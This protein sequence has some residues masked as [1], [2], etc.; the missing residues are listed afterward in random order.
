MDRLLLGLIN[1]PSQ[2]RDE[3]IAE[4]LTNHL[5]QTPSFPFGMD[6]ASINIQ[7]GRDHGVPPY[8]QWRE[9]CGLSPVR[10]FEDL[11]KLLA[12]SAAWKFKLVYPSVE[13]VDLFTAGLAE[14]SVSGGLVGPTFAC[15]IGQQF[16]NLRR[17]DR[18]W[19]E[20]P[21][22]E[23]SFTPGQLQQ[24]RR[25]SLAQ[26]LCSTMDNIDT[27]QPFVFLAQDNLRNHR[28]PC[29]DPAIGRLDLEFWAERLS[30]VRSRAGI[31]DVLKKK[32]TAT[33]AKPTTRE[34]INPISVNIAP[35]KAPP[36]KGSIHQQNRVV[37]K[38]PLGP[39]DNF[40]IV[41]QNNAVNSPIFVN[42]AVYGSNLGGDPLGSQQAQINPSRP[43]SGV[44]GNRPFQHGPLQSIP[45]YVPAKPI[46]ASPPSPLNAP[47]GHPY[48]P[49]AFNDPSNPNP[50][51]QGYQSSYGPSDVV[52]ESYSATTPRPTLYTYYTSFQRPS[53]QRPPHDVDAYLVNYGPSPWPSLESQ[54]Q[55]GG[56]LPRPHYGGPGNQQPHSGSS[57]EAANWQ[58]LQQQHDFVNQPS[59]QG[60]WS[61][62]GYGHR[63][64]SPYPADW[65][66]QNNIHETRPSALPSYQIVDKPYDQ[67]RPLHQPTR[68][69]IIQAYQK[70]SD[71]P[72]IHPATDYNAAFTG[73][74]FPSAADKGAGVNSSTLHSKSPPSPAEGFKPAEDQRPSRPYSVTIVTEATGAGGS[75][76]EVDGIGDRVTSEVPRPLTPQANDNRQVIRRPGQYY[77]EKNV[78]RRYPDK[79]EDQASVHGHGL[80]GSD[81]ELRHKAAGGWEAIGE[82]VIDRFEGSTQV[83]DGNENGSDVAGTTSRA[84][85]ATGGS[86]RDDDAGHG[87]A[88]EIESITSTDRYFRSYSPRLH[89][90]PRARSSPA[91]DK[92]LIWIF[93]HTRHSPFIGNNDSS[94]TRLSHLCSTLCLH[95]KWSNVSQESLVISVICRNLEIPIG[96]CCVKIAFVYPD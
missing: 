4:E 83:A 54:Q 69:P 72:D 24:I 11:E 76:Y 29:G 41:V 25:V 88:E 17:G 6:L 91:S 63:P 68:S 62:Q 89:A 80:A 23:S 5:F 86:V 57:Y 71:R 74:P 8:V 78:L 59:G 10:S 39:S 66:S 30:K 95:E 36:L 21:G 35:Q 58:K 51:S 50:L 16:S 49:Y 19:Y 15:I 14:K 3:H 27:V 48:V 13:D 20:N 43:I 81:A 12:P 96:V 64:S 26:V 73:R 79:I 7:R 34:R 94:R 37:V 56:Q 44:I 55:A 28:L 82:R 1:Q 84:R 61:S 75:G 77:Y 31:L 90:E 32:P 22:Q 65:S 42:D 9:P 46:P 38:K 45:T 52:F 2:R 87:L 47:A 67:H 85:N 60:Y 18:F 53:T 92:I 70:E 40:T 93:A 33:T